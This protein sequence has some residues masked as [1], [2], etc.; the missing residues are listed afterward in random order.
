M[1]QPPRCSKWLWRS[2]HLVLTSRTISTM[3][4]LVSLSRVLGLMEMRYILEDLTLKAG[5]ATW[6]RVATDAYERHMANV[7]VGEVNF[8]GA[9]VNSRYPI[10]ET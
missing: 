2:I 7:I 1:A 6:G 10:C 3:I 8:G 4:R 9:M 5:P